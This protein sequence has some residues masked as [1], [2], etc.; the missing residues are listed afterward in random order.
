MSSSKKRSYDREFKLQAI[1]LVIEQG[2]KL[3]EAAANLGIGV[4]SLG[5]WVR[6]YRENNAP[7]SAFPRKGHLSPHDEEL[8]RLQKQVRKLERERE[9]LKK[10]LGF[11]AENP[12]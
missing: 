12:E 8:K 10:A 6:K 3:T 9:I 5:K 2:Y 11:F 4:S 1:K 7:S